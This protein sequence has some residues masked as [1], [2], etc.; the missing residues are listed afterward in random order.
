MY[1]VRKRFMYWYVPATTKI[2]LNHDKSASYC[3]VSARSAKK[4]VQPVNYIVERM[5]NI[6]T[7]PLM[8]RMIILLPVSNV[9]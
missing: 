6:L 4:A 1:M 7:T 5:T 2:H 8:K 3:F 9:R